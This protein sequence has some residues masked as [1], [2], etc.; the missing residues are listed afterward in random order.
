VTRWPL[1]DAVVITGVYGTGKSSVA[2]EIADALER[3]DVPSGA[4]D[5][6]W[7]TWFHVPATDERVAR[8]VYLAN[9]AAVVGNYR[10]AGVRRLVLAGAVRDRDELAALAAAIGMPLRVVRL[11][12]PLATITER[13]S[14]DPTSGRRDDLAAAARWLDGGIGTGFED[15]TIVNTGSVQQTAATV[16]DWLGWAP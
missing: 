1:P 4:I 2:A 9:V 5:L 3:R 6:D 10:T 14:S 15:V 16:L 11:D 12:V 13:L 8:A 7:L